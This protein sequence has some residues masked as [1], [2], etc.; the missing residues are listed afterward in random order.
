MA[1]KQIKKESQDLDEV[2]KEIKTRYGEERL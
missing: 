2:I 1:K